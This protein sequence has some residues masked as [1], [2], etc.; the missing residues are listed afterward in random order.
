MVFKITWSHG[1]AGSSPAA[2]TKYP[3]I[4]IFEKY[5]TQFLLLPALGFMKVGISDGERVFVVLSWFHYGLVFHWFDI[6]KTN[7]KKK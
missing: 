4:M 1:D 5:D 6:V 2:F 7:R 3:T